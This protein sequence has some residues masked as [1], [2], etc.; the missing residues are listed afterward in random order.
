MVFKVG[1]R[2]AHAGDEAKPIGEVSYGP[3]KVQA[4]S[5]TNWYLVRRPD[6][7]NA[8]FT[9]RDLVPVARFQVGDFV[10]TTYG[11]R[12]K[13]AAG[14]F[15]HEAGSVFYVVSVADGAYDYPIPEEHM[16]EDSHDS[17]YVFRHEGEYYS[18]DRVYV[19][20]DGDDWKYA[21]RV[22]ESGYP[23]LTM[24]GDKGTTMAL[25]HLIEVYGPLT[26]KS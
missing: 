26:E 16:R 3:F 13:V 10:R 7:T 20:R 15:R 2:V 1:Q 11:M 22:D 21:G 25:H 24:L 4:G 19:D 5:S 8:R 9:Q 14:P 6:G 12:V 23:L 18:M 17:E